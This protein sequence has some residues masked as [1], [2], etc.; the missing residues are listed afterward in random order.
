MTYDVDVKSNEIQVSDRLYEYVNNK[1]Q[2]L[3]RFLPGIQNARVELTHAKTSRQAQDRFVAQITISGKGFTLRAEERS[4][5]IFAS[6]DEA[7]D[8]IQRRIER[9]KGKHFRGRGDGT[10]VAEGALEAIEESQEVEMEEEIIVRR[11]KFILIPMDEQDAIEQ[12][13]LLGHEDFFV[14]YNIGTDSVNVL[15]KRRDSNYG[16]IETEVG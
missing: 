2:K 12:S 1:T 10:S 15:Y 14:F 7:V 11:K 9:Y 13:N 4:D 3:E 16:L 8:K 6:F 5:D